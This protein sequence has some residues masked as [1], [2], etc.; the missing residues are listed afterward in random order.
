MVIINTNSWHYKLLR[1]TDFARPYNLCL[2]VRNVVFA[3][4]FCLL[5]IAA[6]LSVI[7][8]MFTVLVYMPFIDHSLGGA[9]TGVLAWSFVGFVALK[10]ARRL[11]NEL[12]PS[13]RWWLI[14][15]YTCPEKPK[16][17]SLS[18][19][20]LKALHDRICPSIEFNQE[21]KR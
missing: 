7:G 13:S 4:F 1:K 17:D 5:T 16:Y 15:I 14:D 10:I 6:I 3:I 9:V 12:G 2:Y 21:T 11:R 20:H 18:M 8:I 19:Q